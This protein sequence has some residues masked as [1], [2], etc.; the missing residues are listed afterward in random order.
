MSSENTA[1]T[2]ASILICCNEE[3]CTVVSGTTIAAFLAV[4]GIPNIAGVAVAIGGT[5]VPRGAWDRHE[6]KLHDEL[7]IITAAQGG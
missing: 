1:D 3:P 5:V 2:T 4:R 6:L 7:L